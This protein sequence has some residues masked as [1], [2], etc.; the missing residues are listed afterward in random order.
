MKVVKSS[1]P[2]L[3]VD[4][5]A[6]QRNFRAAGSIVGSDVEVCAVVK[7]D[8]Y[9]LGIDKIV[10]P[11]VAAG[12][13]SFFVADFEEAVRVRRRAA[14][15]KVFIL[16]GA[17]PSFAEFYRQNDFIPVC[18]TLC[19]A[20]E[21]ASLRCQY[22][23]NVETGLSRFGLTFGEFRTLVHCRVRAPVLIMSHLACADAPGNPLNLLQKSRFM[24]MC[25]LS[26]ATP[27]SLAASA[28]I[29]LG[30]AYHF[31]LARI[32]SALYGLNNA[33]LDPNP[34][35][36]VVRLRARIADIRLVRT[37]EAVGYMSTFRAQ[38]PTWV[39]ILAIGYSHG[40]A[41][42]GSNRLW[43][44]IGSH[45]APLVG[46]V[47]MEFAAI[48]MTDLPPSLRVSGRW[49]DLICPK[50]PAE[51]MAHTAGT[52]PQET[53]VRIGSTNTRHYLEERRQAHT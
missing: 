45:Q 48:D 31:D 34:F 18:N 40:L 42:S 44:Q 15:A 39:G 53:L 2:Q 26:G 38:R 1:G 11:L 20:A 49:V 10:G 28:G 46:R 22:A 47:A 3:F 5:D 4:L 50:L 16:R 7:S 36:N 32:G 33:S 24:A 37:G 9:G 52:I 29:S 21:I 17:K 13:H 35:V 6:I 14:V 19:E 8:A 41:W 30:P 27:R 43:V 12:C 23:L 51:L 25:E